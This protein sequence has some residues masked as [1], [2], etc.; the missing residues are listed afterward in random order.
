[1]QGVFVRMQRLISN[2]PNDFH[3]E[4]VLIYDNST[5]GEREKKQQQQH[6]IGHPLSRAI[7]YRTCLAISQNGLNECLNIQLGSGCF[8]TIWPIKNKK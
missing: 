8:C 3:P 7:R 4:T 1:M 5:H 6:W 2:Q